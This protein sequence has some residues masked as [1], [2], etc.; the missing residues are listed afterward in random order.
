MIDLSNL[1]NA[2]LAERLRAE[3]G[4]A[5]LGWVR[6]SLVR[7]AAS[8]LQAPA[9]AE[10]QPMDTA[11]KDGKHCILSVPEPSGFIY[12]VQGAFQEGRWNAAHRDNVEPIAWMPNVLL[13]ESI[14]S[15]LRTGGSE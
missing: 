2:E 9:V 5:R 13:P 6:T 15:A 12:S 4:D 14:R 11:P 1:S 7:E 10:W 3:A 8:R